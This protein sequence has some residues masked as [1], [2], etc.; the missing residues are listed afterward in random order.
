VESRL[1]PHPLGCGRVR[2]SEAVRLL[3]SEIPVSW[4]QTATGR[5]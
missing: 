4:S 1:G 2:A 3:E 5:W